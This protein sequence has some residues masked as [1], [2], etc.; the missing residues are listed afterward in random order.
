MFTAAWCGPCKIAGQ[1]HGLRE[2]WPMGFRPSSLWHLL[3]QNHDYVQCAF[4][5]SDDDLDSRVG[6]VPENGLHEGHAFCD[7]FLADIVDPASIFNNNY[8]MFLNGCI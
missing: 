3:M 1:L 8:Y 5:R 6:G 4:C 7:C 2:S